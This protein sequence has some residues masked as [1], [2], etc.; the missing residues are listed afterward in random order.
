MDP[1]AIQDCVVILKRSLTIP[2]TLHWATVMLRNGF[3][4]IVANLVE[5]PEFQDGDSYLEVRRILLEILK[6]FIPPL[7]VHRS[8]ALTAVRAV[9][10]TTE[11]GSVKRIESSILSDAWKTFSNLVLER[12]I[13]LAIYKRS[14]IKEIFEVKSCTNVS[15]M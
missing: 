5:L 10:S 8:F 3:L 11:K 9:K 15:I 12:T 2:G 7:L 14:R 13:Y 4:E 1:S 6:D